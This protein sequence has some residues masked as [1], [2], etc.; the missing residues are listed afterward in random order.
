MVARDRLESAI[1]S[2][3]SM[4]TRMSLASM[5]LVLSCLSHL[6]CVFVCLALSCLV[7]CL[8]LSLLWFLDIFDFRQTPLV[9]SIR[10][11]Q[12]P[13]GTNLR[14]SEN[15]LKTTTKM[16]CRTKRPLNWRFNRCWKLWT[17]EARTLKLLS[18]E[19]DS[20]FRYDGGRG[21]GGGG[22]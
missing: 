4:Q 12:L 21:K 14:T 8:F 16:T 18:C 13:L 2:L 19:K 15:I 1:W 11:G 3:A 5:Q 7:S 17:P 9:S 6:V 20:L 22:G 10:G